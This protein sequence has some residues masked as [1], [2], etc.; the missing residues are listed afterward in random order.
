MPDRLSAH[1]VDFVLLHLP[2][3]VD[4]SAADHCSS[5]PAQAVQRLSRM[6]FLAAAK[7]K[8]SV[9]RIGLSKDTNPQGRQNRFA[10][11]TEEPAWSLNMCAY[12]AP[13]MPAHRPIKISLDMS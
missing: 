4:A 9:A 13:R 12:G 1:G 3:K 11:S 6:R 2:G 8:I 5:T 10:F 7:S